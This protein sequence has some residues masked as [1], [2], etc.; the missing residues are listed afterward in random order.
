MVVNVISLGCK[1]N[2]YEVEA[3]KADFLA[4]GFSEVGIPNVIVINTCSVTSVADQKSRQIIRRYRRNY[5]NAV[6]IVMGCFVQF[7]YELIDEENIA[8]IIVG[9]AYRNEI[10]DLYLTYLK[11]KKKIIKINKDTRASRA[12]ES[13]NNFINPSSTRAFIKIQDGC[14][15]FCTYCIIPY[16]RGK[17][18]SR[19]ED[20]IIEEIKYL[21]N[22]GFKEFVLSGIDTSRYGKDLGISFS[23]LVRRI[24]RLPGLFRLRISSIEE[25]EID[26]ELI[27]LFSE[28]PNI[29]NQIHIPLQSGS[30][31]IIKLMNRKYD[32]NSFIEKVNRLKKVRPDISLTSDVIVG[33]PGETDKDFFDTIESIKKIGFSSLHVFPYS[34]RSGTIASKMT[35]QVSEKTKKERVKILMDLSNK[36]H[37]EYASKFIGSEV[38]VIFEERNQKTGLISGFTSNYL[39]VSA[40]DPNIKVGEIKKIIYQKVI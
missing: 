1:V 3:V 21:I 8:D 28:F 11:S 20:E 16:T 37:Y 33:F 15:N 36:L 17:A 29:A 7:N 32:L 19:S 5:P 26:D 30:K 13:F 34:K 35:N 23:H 14:D 24:L 6:I 9:T 10:Y 12:Y 22:R 31:K 4:R 27:D 18:R 25:S 2:S 38:E 40:D 39:K